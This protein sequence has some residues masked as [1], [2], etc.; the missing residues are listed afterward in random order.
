MYDRRTVHLAE[1]RRVHSIASL[2]MRHPLHLSF[3]MCD[4]TGNV[5]IYLKICTN[6]RSF[7]HHL[8]LVSGV[9]LRGVSISWSFSSLQTIQVAE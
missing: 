4:L 7:H 3:G 6:Y 9:G 8:P 2:A 1:Y 5:K